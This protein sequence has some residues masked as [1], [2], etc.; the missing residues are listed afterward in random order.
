VVALALAAYPPLTADRSQAL[1][2]ALGGVAVAVLVVALAL[3]RPGWIVTPVVLLGASYAVSL[4]LPER[5]VDAW[6]PVVATALVVLAELSYWAAELRTPVL[7]EPGILPRRAAYIAVEAMAALVTGAL[8]LAAATVSV[9]GGLV[10]DA[11]GVAAAI[12]IFVLVARLAR[13][14]M[15]SAT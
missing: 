4:F 10:W 8:V 13:A 12:A 11:A 14:G 15:T 7:A 9:G 6:A 3:S 1:L 5:S 2:A